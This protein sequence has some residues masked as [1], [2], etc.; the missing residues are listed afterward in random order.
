MSPARAA[1]IWCSP[2]SAIS[3]LVIVQRR[4]NDRVR[5][6]MTMMS[7]PRSQPARRT[8][9]FAAVLVGVSLVL[10]T[11][12]SAARMYQWREAVTGS[13]QLAG[14]PP[15]WYRNGAPGPRVR[16]FERGRVVDDTAHDIDSA[17]EAHL[18]AT[19]HGAP[20]AAPVPLPATATT[21]PE[22]AD[23][24]QKFKALLQEWDQTQTPPRAPATSATQALPPRD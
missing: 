21:L 6:S 15:P 7:H 9:R 8:K 5:L 19:A 17:R 11:L 23:Q 16:V 22:T 2:S 24:M 4:D 12:P 14:K 10:T 3:L 20:V 1:L 13:I 18:R